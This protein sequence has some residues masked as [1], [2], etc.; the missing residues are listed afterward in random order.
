M[1]FIL[2]ASLVLAIAELVLLGWLE[3]I[4]LRQKRRSGRPG[5]DPAPVSRSKAALREK[6]LSRPA[7]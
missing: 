3:S 5:H 4:R 2:V 1:N 7:P 6:R